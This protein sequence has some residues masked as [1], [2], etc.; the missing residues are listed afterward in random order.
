[1]EDNNYVFFGDYDNCHFELLLVGKDNDIRHSQHFDNKC[2]FSKSSRLAF[3]YST[4]VFKF[5]L[6]SKSAASI[7]NVVFVKSSVT[8]AICNWVAIQ[9]YDGRDVICL[10]FT[11][12]LNP[13]E[14]IITRHSID[15][16]CQFNIQLFPIDWFCLRLQSSLLR[17]TTCVAASRMSMPCERRLLCAKFNYNGEY[18]QHR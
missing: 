15:R 8:N 12:R 18:F 1:M 11:V 2:K 4:S 10:M 17:F 3:E 14:L 7:A 13:I 9:C 6:R 16:C 5:V